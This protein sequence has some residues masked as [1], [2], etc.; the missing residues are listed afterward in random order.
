MPTLT[1]TT[2]PDF[3]FW[4]TAVGHGWCDLP[5]FTCDEDARVL[6]R[7]FQFTDG[8]IVRLVLPAHDAAPGSLL[9]HVEGLPALTP[10]QSDQITRA[11]RRCLE[12]DRDMSP[13]YALVR[14][15]PR[16]QWIA[17]LGAGR[18]LASPTLWEDLVKTLMTTNTTWN[19]TIQMVSRIVT[20]GDPYAAGGHAFP[21]PQRIAALSLDDLNTHIRAGYRGAYLHELATRLATAELEVESWRDLAIPSDELYKR[22]KSLKGFGDYAAGNLMRL[23]GHFD[24]L[25]TDTECRAVYRDSINNGV[26]AAH[27]REIAAYYHPLGRGAASSNGWTSWSVTS[28]ASAFP[29]KKGGGCPLLFPTIVG[30]IP[31]CR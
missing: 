24:R 7:L 1:L 29:N 5:P 10:A 30:F 25:A 14:Q 31:S 23:M 21:T 12:I 27:D 6:T 2:P 13:F 15:H 8:A 18:L 20:L 26:P 19:M 4:P 3:R 11:L 22:I 9:V 16:Y 17:Q 28:R